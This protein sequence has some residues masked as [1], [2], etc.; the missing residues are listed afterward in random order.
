M[1]Q[2]TVISELSTFSQ[3]IKLL[4]PILA[5][6]IRLLMEARIWKYMLIK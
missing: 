1:N 2:K 3:N 5:Y 6:P 4:Y